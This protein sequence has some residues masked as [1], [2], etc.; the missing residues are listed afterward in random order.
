MFGRF[1][2][3]RSYTTDLVAGDT[4]S[5]RRRLRPADPR[6]RPGVTGDVRRVC[7]ASASATAGAR[8]DAAAP[9]S[10]RRT[11]R[12]PATRASAVYQSGLHQPGGWRHQRHGRRLHPRRH[13][14]Q[15]RVR[16]HRGARCP[17]TRRL[18]TSSASTRARNAGSPFGDPDGD[19]FTNDAGAHRPAAT[20]TR[21]SA[22]SRATSPRARPR[23]PA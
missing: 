6:Q 15:R 12:S 7:C 17:A 21:C 20:A 4:N 19:G 5:A 23:P 22:P 2:A 16:L 1:L 8:G 18:P 10:T 13:L 3:F 9:A 14:R 11:R